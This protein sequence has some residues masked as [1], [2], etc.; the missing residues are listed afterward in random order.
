MQLLP[1]NPGGP[2]PVEVRLAVISPFVD[3][4]HGTERCLA[5]QL[6]RF[7][8]QPDAEVHL[9]AQRVEDLP[10]TVRY[11]ARTPGHVILH[12]VP[13][14]RGPHLVGYAWWFLANY[15]Q[16]WWDS[17]VRGLKFDLLYSPGIN[18]FDADAI[19]IHVVF[20]EFYRRVRPRLRLAGAPVR[21]LVLNL[22]RQLYYTLIS[23]LE[24]RIYPRP[25]ISLTAISAHSSECVRRFFRRDDVLVV[26]YG[27]DT[28]T[29]H[30]AARLKRRE[31]ERA[32]LGLS[33]PDFCLL[34]I[35]ND[36]KSKGLD[37]LLTALGHCSELSF[38]A[39]VAGQ[40][41]RL[42]HES[43]IRQLR[44]EH[45]IRFVG[46][47]RDVMQFYAVA[48]TYVAPSLEDAYGLPI[49]EAMACGL[50]VIAS[51]RAGASEIIR[52]GEDGFRLRDPEDPRELAALLRKVYSDVPLRE[53][54]SAQAVRTAAE[55]T[56]DR[57]ATATWEFLSAALARKRQ[58]SV[59]GRPFA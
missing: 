31:A 39:V 13:R 41:D 19:S 55:H 4:R 57:N 16:R 27:V 20:T 52:D 29:F 42:A 38:V 47:S 18:A 9:Y 36:W 12:R 22:H 2:G 34:L 10:N 44:L 30:P 24:R 6:E 32:S 14:L 23:L 58:R 1:C 51:S 33:D 35:G 59:K 17:K 54:I 49:L 45:R 56:W 46:S 48:D 8:A 50:P 21:L 53:K 7:S 26:R 43:Q 28:K 15:V 37:T 11:P 5:E 3:R 25:S 40:G